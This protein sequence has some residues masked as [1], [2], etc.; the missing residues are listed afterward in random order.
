MMQRMGMKVDEI[1]SVTQVVI[2]TPT[3]NIVI[4]GPSVAS[5]MMQGQKMFQ[6]VGGKISEQPAVS[7]TPQPLSL[8]TTGVGTA[9]TATAPS[10]MAIPQEDVDLVASQTGRSKEDAKRALQTSGGDLAKAILML[11]SEKA[12]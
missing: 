3:R 1:S 6:V 12:Q 9:Q 8:P 10:V 7:A 11:Q 5:I 2:R 4:D